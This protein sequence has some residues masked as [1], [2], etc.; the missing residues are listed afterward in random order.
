MVQM[1]KGS[2]NCV[3]VE[4]SSAAVGKEKYESSEFY[5]DNVMTK[6]M[7]NNRTDAPKSDVNLLNSR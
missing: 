6:F 4:Y 3:I 1:V 7:I 2:K 5:F